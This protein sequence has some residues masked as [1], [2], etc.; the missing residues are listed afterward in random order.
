MRESELERRLIYS[1]IVAG[2]SAKFADGA[3]DRLFCLP[4]NGQSYFSQIVAWIA[5]GGLGTVLRLA[6]TG[7]YGKLERCL[8]ELVKDCPDLKTCSPW[9]LEKIHGI[10]P[11]T[12][13]FFILWTRPNALHAALDVHILR[14]LGKMGYSVPRSTPQSTKKYIEIERWFL[15]EAGK[16]GVTAREL[17]HAIWVEGAKHPERTEQT[18][19]L[20]QPAPVFST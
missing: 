14:W 20:V 16:R 11:K 17:D 2:K 7:N 12:S 15:H 9:A 5:L 6:R 3:M 4:Q 1:V 18:K 10:G 8:R 19:L 13:R